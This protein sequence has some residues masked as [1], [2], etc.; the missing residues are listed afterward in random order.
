MGYSGVIALDP[1]IRTFM[2]GYDPSGLTVKWGNGDV[3]RIYRLCFIHD[4]IQGRRDVIRGKKHKH[5]RYKLRK[6]ML[7]I[8]KKIRCIVDE[9]H[10]K[11]AK[12]LCENYR[13]V[14]LP[15]FKTQG[16]T[17]R[18]QRRIHSKTARAM[19]TWSHYRFRQHLLHKAREHP[20]CHVILCSEE[21]TSK[22]CGCCGNIH[23]RLGGSKVFRCP[24]STCKVEVD[25]DFNGARNIFLRY[26]TILHERKRKQDPDNTGDGA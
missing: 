18:G 7:R 26:L 25:R 1:G 14:L 2:T 16:M 9:C 13:V 6:V 20:W 12:W 4:M 24:L 8:H 21:Y 5:K 17:R 11:L 23:D 3:E 19:C 15:E 10:R 22:T